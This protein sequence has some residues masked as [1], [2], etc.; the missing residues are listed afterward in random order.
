MPS[1]PRINITIDTTGAER[2]VEAFAEFAAAVSRLAEMLPAMPE[3]EAA[4]SAAPP[5]DDNST[6]DTP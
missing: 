3:A 5:A 6:E 1:D 2:A 4:A